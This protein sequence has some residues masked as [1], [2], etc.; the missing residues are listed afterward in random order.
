MFTNASDISSA[1]DGGT[2][3]DEEYISQLGQRGREVLSVNVFTSSFEGQVE[4]THMYEYGKDFFIGDIIQ[5]ANE[6]GMEAKARVVEL[7]R[8]QNTSGINIYP[9]FTAI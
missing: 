8:S 1:I 4:I 3:T 2:L 7:I 6:Y 9:T 5:I